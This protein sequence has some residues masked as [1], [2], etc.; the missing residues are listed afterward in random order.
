MCTYF[1]PRGDKGISLIVT[2]EKLKVH[3][4]EKTREHP[5]NTDL[6]I[7]R[8]IPRE[9]DFPLE[10][11]VTSL[12]MTPNSPP[13]PIHPHPPTHRHFLSSI[14]CG[15]VGGLLVKAVRI[16]IGQVCAQLSW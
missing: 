9:I 4:D 11:E 14:D 2:R 5:N 16:H 10:C 15:V 12:A 3:M 7:V 1:S 8:E 6:S 13:P